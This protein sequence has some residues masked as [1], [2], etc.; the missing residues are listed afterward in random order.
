M[1]VIHLR[2]L[3]LMFELGMENVV[4]RWT[5]FRFP[6]VLPLAKNVTHSF[7]WNGY[8]HH[9]GATTIVLCRYIISSFM[10]GG[11][12]G[13][14]GGGG[15]RHP[16]LILWE[17]FLCLVNQSDYI[18]LSEDIAVTRWPFGIWGCA[19]IIVNF[20]FENLRGNPNASLRPP[21]QKRALL[22]SASHNS[23][24]RDQRNSQLTLLLKFSY[25][26]VT[27]KSQAECVV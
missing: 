7:K 3:K 8:L 9:Q 4:L 17:C 5:I 23:K 1:C 13:G 2:R 14:G 26:S 21:S 20:Y 10:K 18:W 6:F 16:T 12:R 11:G 22:Q 25:T 15:G 27:C 19:K 24:L